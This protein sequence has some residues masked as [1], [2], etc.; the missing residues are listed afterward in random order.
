MQSILK[1]AQVKK[2]PRKMH[3]LLIKIKV[4]EKTK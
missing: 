1:I 4:K 2:M 3:L